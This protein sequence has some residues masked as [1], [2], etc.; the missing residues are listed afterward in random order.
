A[1]Q[2]GNEP[3]GMEGLLML[4]RDFSEGKH[5]HLAKKLNLLILP[6]CNPSGAETHSR[7]TAED[8]DLN[9]DH[10]LCRAAETRLI[11]RIY[12][13]YKS[14]MTIDFHEYY[15]F[16]SAWADF[17]FRRNFDIQL[18]GLTN[19]NVHPE[20]RSLFK[21]AAL[22][23]VEEKVEKE[24][25]SFFEYTLGDFPNDKRLRHS[26]V[27]INDGRQSFGIAGSF[28]VIV[29]GMNGRDS[30]DNISRRAQSQYVT[31]LALL[32]FAYLKADA[33][34]EATTLARNE[35]IEKQEMV[36][37]RMDHFRGNVPLR[38][39]LLNLR[40]NTDT[41]FLVEEYH[42]E[43]VSLLDVR[44]PEAYLIPKRDTMLSEWLKRS[45]LDYQ[46]FMPNDLKVFV[47]RI[48]AV[49]PGFDE[50]F[51]NLYPDVQKVIS[52]NFSADDYFYLPTGG[53]FKHKIVTALEPQALYGLASY[54]EFEYL[55]MEDTFPVFRVEK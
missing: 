22:P 5:A 25:F 1:Q 27:D 44:P 36:S 13:Q 37:I 14:E 17:G 20:L 16:G 28:S 8:I 3:S 19:I 7:R 54:P 52:K 30:L 35:L 39:P 43:V 12:S 11:Q 6:Q 38:Y 55:L 9:R 42:S 50:E 2:H 15:P 23:F 34:R 10:L 51:A 18:G 4:I 53:I 48:K 33:I 24:N 26:T 29:E 49:N 46:E 40:T 45:G 47:Y 31:A 21:E 32:E 41:V